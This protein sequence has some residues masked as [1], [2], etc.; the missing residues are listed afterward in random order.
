MKDNEIYLKHI[1]D[2][3]HKI[4][5]YLD[6]ISFEEFSGDEMRVGATVRELEI[7]GEAA[8]KL[9]SSFRQNHTDIQ[10]KSIIGMRNFLIHQYFGVSEKVIWGTY[11]NDLDK[12]EKQITDLLK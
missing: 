4:R 3:I 5:R 9:S 12:L 1:L 7:I 8:S 10:W 6:G 2:S 11:K